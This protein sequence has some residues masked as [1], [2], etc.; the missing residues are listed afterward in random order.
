MK[1]CILELSMNE[2]RAVFMDNQ[3]TTEEDGGRNVHSTPVDDDMVRMALI[4]SSSSQR[5][6]ADWLREYFEKYAEH[7]PDRSES[8]VR[9]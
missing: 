5:H 9:V 8:K 7:A 4:P 2:A 1:K 6:C 3:I